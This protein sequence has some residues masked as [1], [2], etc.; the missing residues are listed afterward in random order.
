VTSVPGRDTEEV[1][2][3]HSDD[4]PAREVETM[5][6]AL[7][8][9]IAWQVDRGGV[10]TKPRSADTIETEKGWAFFNS[11]SYFGTVTRE[12]A[13]IFETRFVASE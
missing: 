9:L 10:P 6:Q 7:D 3:M 11:E 8:D 13:V 2:S 12:G 5:A 1:T 4:T